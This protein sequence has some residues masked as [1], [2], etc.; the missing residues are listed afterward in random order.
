MRAK[1]LYF[2]FD[3]AGL[4]LIDQN[5]PVQVTSGPVDHPDWLRIRFKVTD[6]ATAVPL[7]PVF[8]G[9]MF[10][11][12]DAPT[13]T[14]VLPAIDFAFQW[15]AAE[16]NGWQTTGRLG[17]TLDP[18]MLTE[19][20]KLPGAPPL[21]A[22]RIWFWPVRVP[23][24]L[25]YGPLRNPAAT[26]PMFR[27]ADI[28]PPLGAKIAKGAGAWPAAATASFISGDYAPGI[29]W[30]KNDVTK[31]GFAQS[32]LPV[33]EPQ[34]DGTVEFWIATALASEDASIAD[35]VYG[36]A[37]LLGAYAG[38]V[39]ELSPENPLNA[40]INARAFLTGLR[41]QMIGADAPNALADAMFPAPA[42]AATRV[43]IALLGTQ[44][45]VQTDSGVYLYGALSK[46]RIRVRGAT[47]S[48]L[49]DRDVPLHGQVT[50]TL[51]TAAAELPL[52][53]DITSPQLEVTRSPTA[54]LAG[55]WSIAAGDAGKTL[56]FT[57]APRAPSEALLTR[58]ALDLSQ[59]TV[60]QEMTRK[61]LEES[62]ARLRPAVWPD[63]DPAFPTADG[64]GNP[65]PSKFVFVGT[66]Q[67]WTNL[68]EWELRQIIRA[69]RGITGVPAGITVSSAHALILWA[70]EG[71][72][73]ATTN[74]FVATIPISQARSKLRLRT[75]AP[76]GRKSA[77]EYDG[78]SPA[79]I[80][81]FVRMWAF[82]NLLGLDDFNNHAGVNDNDPTFDPAISIANLAAA[83]DTAFNA[84]R[85]R[86]VLAGLNPPDLATINAAFTVA[87]V[88]AGAGTDWE[89][90]CASDCVE[91][92]IALQYCE[93]LRRVI[94]LPA[95]VTGTVAD[96]D[97]NPFDVRRFPAFHYMAFN[98][99]ISVSRTNPA[100]NPAKPV[101]VEWTRA[102]G[103]VNTVGCPAAD[104][105]EAIMCT[106]VMPQEIAAI[107][108]MRNRRAVARLNGAQFGVLA[109]TY[110]RVFPI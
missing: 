5:T 95:S 63:P 99:G 85:D 78:A 30:D 89:F 55:P 80:R 98:G 57:I 79:H 65:I 18:T 37:A 15:T 51:P 83:H 74:A 14:K 41:S 39:P 6:P 27:Q 94:A 32:T 109:E 49:Q 33:L 90:R 40:S 7:R 11:L 20:R 108:R 68:N 106:K 84:A 22:N 87:Q 43:Q 1:F 34:A 62:D 81:T 35:G 76:F 54:N 61:R 82:F 17:V 10:F 42:P 59:S 3:A 69:V 67:P 4:A 70:L 25:L 56:R 31:D 38:A 86:I 103:E 88:G 75:L 47:G 96:P 21:F 19:L 102:N 8:S 52:A 105:Q 60:T 44:D 48:V 100:I 16:Y 2:P 58:L 91:R 104:P 92:I 13:S 28:R 45:S 29:L 50:V 72:L 101:F 26:N 77:T 66:R 93:F 97:G 9:Q 71:K 110:G 12:P 107:I 36:M 73:A 46:S 23:Q 64:V 24:A 53:V